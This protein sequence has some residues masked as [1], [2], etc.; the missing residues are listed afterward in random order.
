MIDV[1]RCPGSPVGRDG[2]ERSPAGDERHV[3]T[4]AA[5]ETRRRLQSRHRVSRR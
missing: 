4:V 2:A 1:R 5:A 3:R